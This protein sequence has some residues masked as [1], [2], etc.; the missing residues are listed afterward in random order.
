MLD[1]EVGVCSAEQSSDNSVKFSHVISTECSRILFVIFSA[2]GLVVLLLN[3][4]AFPFEEAACRSLCKLVNPFLIRPASFLLKWSQEVARGRD[5]G[6]NCF[7]IVLWWDLSDNLL[8]HSAPSDSSQVCSLPISNDWFSLFVNSNSFSFI[9]IS[10]SR[11]SSWSVGSHWLV[12][13]YLNRTDGG[14]HDL[15]PHRMYPT[16]ESYI[17]YRNHVHLAVMLNALKKSKQQLLNLFARFEDYT[18]LG[19]KIRHH[20]CNLRHLTTIQVLFIWYRV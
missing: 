8:V 14:R 11:Y 6:R 20:A 18:V 12:L 10:I 5:K 7:S 19:S 9:V 13:L 16:T 4:V 2:W 17:T 15:F 1:P 3:T